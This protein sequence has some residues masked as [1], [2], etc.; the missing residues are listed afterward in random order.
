MKLSLQEAEAINTAAKV[1]QRLARAK[2]AVEASLEVRADG[3]AAI[4][5]DDSRGFLRFQV[6]ADLLPGGPLPTPSDAIGRISENG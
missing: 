1:L 6:L 4:C 2:G 3:R 5:A